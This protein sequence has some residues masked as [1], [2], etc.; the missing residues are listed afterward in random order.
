MTPSDS[1]TPT[2]PDDD[3]LRFAGELAEIAGSVIRPY[4]RTPVAVDDKPDSSPVT[5]ADREAEQA[6][7]RAI[8]ERFPDHGIIGE[9]FASLRPDADYLWILDPIDGTKQFI[10]GKPTFG[11]LIALLHR[12]TPILG[13]IDIPILGE[14]WLG[15]LGQPTTFR[16]SGGEQHVRCRSCPDPAR[17]MFYTTAPENFLDR[18]RPR[19]QRLSEAVKVPS[20]GGDCFNYGLLAGGFC[21]L[22]VDG[23][24]DG[25]DFAALIPIIEGAGG[26]IS[27]AEGN[28]L[29]PAEGE[30]D[31]VVA[32][33][34]AR[35]HA[36]ALDILAG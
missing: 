13:V 19:L 14:R 9:E 27:D 5:I 3:L 30:C 26:I 18:D 16:D 10:T 24:M 20:Y 36:A 15:A 23:T 7:R 35:T 34:D 6:M 11:T 22:V 8:E 4:Y 31:F 29:R 12:E 28:R 17:A 21:D 25:H 2:T 1:A 33:G 32:A